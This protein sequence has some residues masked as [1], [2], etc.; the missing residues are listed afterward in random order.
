[1]TQ[2]AHSISLRT[3]VSLSNAHNCSSRTDDFAGAEA[4]TK[5]AALVFRV[6]HADL[7]RWDNN[8]ASA[9]VTPL[10]LIGHAP[11]TGAHGRIF[12]LL[13]IFDNQPRPPLDVAEQTQLQELA[14]IAAER[15]ELAAHRRAAQEAIYRGSFQHRLLH[16]V[17][18]AD[19]FKTACDAVLDFLLHETGAI[20]C[21]LYRRYPKDDRIRLFAGVGIGD[22]ASEETLNELRALQTTVENSV[23]GQAMLS[24]QQNIVHDVS[25]LDSVRFPA[26]AILRK[27]GAESA[28]ITP[29]MMGDECHVISLG[30]GPEIA[31]LEGIAELIRLAAEMLR[32]MLRRL[33]DE[34]E[35]NLF[36]RAMEG[37]PDPVLICDMGTPTSGPR[38]QHCNQ[39]FLT[40]TGYSR[41]EILGHTANFLQGP[42]SDPVAS[43]KIGEA[44][45]N[46][47]SL[48][49]Q[50]VNHR[51]N[52]TIYTADLHIAPIFDQS[53]WQTH[54]VG[55]QRD[56]T[57][58]RDAEAMREMALRQMN[59]LFDAMP[60]ALLHFRRVG[61]NQWRR[62]FTSPSIARLT[63][64]AY[65]GILEHGWMRARI[66]PDEYQLLLDHFQLAY[67]AGNSVCEFRLQHIDG[68][69]RLI[70]SQM[71]G[72]T[73][74][75]G[76]REVLAI[77]TDISR[78][79]G[80]TEQLN[81]A[82]KLAE[83]G[84]M[85]AGLAHELNRPLASITLAAENAAH[86]ASGIRAVPQRLLDKLEM[87]ADIALRAAQV[88]QHIQ[89]FGR[90]EKGESVPVNL[91][92]MMQ[93][94]HLLAHA[95]LQASG[96]HLQTDIPD[97]LPSLI[98]RHIP[99]QQVLLNLISNAADAYDARAGAKT[100]VPRAVFISARVVS[101]GNVI[102]EVR[103]QAGG[104][105]EDAMP[106]LFEAFFTTRPAG[107]GTGLGL[108]ISAGI[109]ADMGGSIAVKNDKGGAV[110]AI[111]LPSQAR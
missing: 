66:R 71:C 30:F 8:T 56:I 107:K 19:N 6:A 45:R 36:R 82:S 1:M 72:F 96:V 69:L 109:V 61:P 92:Q 84:S 18:D 86:M 79:R 10:A 16:L 110:F 100:N 68:H 21:R 70:R 50:V 64:Y 89:V 76:E 40:Q 7:G 91:N 31:D 98:A 83:L 73:P 41:G 34:A 20:Y 105:P 47:Q 48:R 88:V 74:P 102:I 60:G 58:Q 57:A 24:G 81:Q 99:L 38:I 33:M 26:A 28:I 94:I 29:L 106:H 104:V 53:G 22:L 23:A 103:D 2:Q 13:R 14:N 77:W 59:A 55:V 85:A 63:G 101:K 51:K 12:G 67:D 46:G 9:D 78:E 15:I 49:Q 95:R 80:L 35:A 90:L 52:G 43:A 111:S 3:A 44:L 62:A 75:H 11:V 37:S 54:W 97:D 32:P 5:V 108:S 42:H 65:D 17:L 87:I 27:N 39:A 25:A 93:D 4:V